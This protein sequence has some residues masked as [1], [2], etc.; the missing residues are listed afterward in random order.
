MSGDNVREECWEEIGRTVPKE[1]A[2]GGTYRMKVPGGWIVRTCE[3]VISD[4]KNYS[5]KVYQN[6]TFVA[7]P[8]HK[9]DIASSRL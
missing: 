5:Y 4:K 6:M 3:Y 9:W 8:E 7:D 2:C 1:T